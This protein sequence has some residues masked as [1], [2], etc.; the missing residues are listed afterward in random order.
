MPDAK[1][2]PDRKARAMSS[3]ASGSCLPNFLNRRF[4][5]HNSQIRGSVLPITAPA[6]SSG[7]GA[8]VMAMPANPM[9]AQLP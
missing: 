6:G 2:C 8:C 9:A 1:L 5:R 3:R 4:R 7:S